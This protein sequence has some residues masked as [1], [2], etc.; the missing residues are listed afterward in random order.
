MGDTKWDLGKLNTGERA[1][2]RRAAGTVNK[3]AD[4]AALRALYTACGY[5]DPNVEE[6]WF[7]AMCMDALW[8][9]MEGI[10][11]KPMDECLKSLLTGDEKTTASL[12]H[13]IEMLLETP[14]NEDGFLLGKLLNLVKILKS[15]TYMKPDFQALADDLRRWNHPDR[16]IQRKWLRTLYNAKPNDKEE[17]ETQNVD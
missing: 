1:A 4:M 10:A 5:C 2:L 8:R 17:E 15:R 3:K 11:V 9:D 14:W 16:Y 7:P 6:Y 12:K 13:R